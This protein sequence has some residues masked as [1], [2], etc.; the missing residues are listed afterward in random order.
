[1]SSENKAT[2]LQAEKPRATA[3]VFVRLLNLSD[4]DIKLRL[5]D[6]LTFS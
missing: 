4:F 3:S 5:Y 6:Q 2:W 1:M